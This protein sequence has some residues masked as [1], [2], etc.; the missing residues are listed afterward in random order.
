MIFVGQDDSRPRPDP[1]IRGLV[2]SESG[3]YFI[4]KYIVN[5]SVYAGSGRVYIGFRCVWGAR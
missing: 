1:V 5:T 3:Q 4:R 2:R